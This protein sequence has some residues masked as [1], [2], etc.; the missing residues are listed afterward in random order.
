MERAILKDLTDRYQWDFKGGAEPQTV[1]LQNASADTDAYVRFA[2][3]YSATIP[4]SSYFDMIVP[5]GGTTII[6]LEKFSCKICMSNP[7]PE[8]SIFR[9]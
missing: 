7:V 6:T 2:A 4:S 3:D 5:F 9:W 8:L 1:R